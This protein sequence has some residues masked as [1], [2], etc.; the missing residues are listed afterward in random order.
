MPN[1]RK[2]HAITVTVNTPQ[3]EYD[4]GHGMEADSLDPVV[5]YLLKR[6]PN[7]TSMVICVVMPSREGEKSNE[8]A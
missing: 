3:G 4:H 6:Y 2:Y 1:T 8:K 5:D 7:C